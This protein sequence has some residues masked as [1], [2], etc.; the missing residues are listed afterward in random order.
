M[1]SFHELVRRQAVERISDYLE[2]YANYST[3]DIDEYVAN[4]SEEE[5][6]T[7]YPVIRAT[8]E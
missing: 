3:T 5:V 8:A 6:W 4:I 2:D 7:D 1:D